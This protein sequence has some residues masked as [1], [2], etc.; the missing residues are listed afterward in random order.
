MPKAGFGALVSSFAPTA[1]TP[2]DQ[3]DLAWLFFT[4]GT[5]GQLKCLEITH[6]MMQ[7]MALGYFFNADHVSDIDIALYAAPML[8]S[9]T[10]YPNARAQ[11]GKAYLP[12]IR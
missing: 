2:R 10:L 6:G 8:H 11:E 12:R 9:T 7:A 1:M 5:T 3:N 4:S